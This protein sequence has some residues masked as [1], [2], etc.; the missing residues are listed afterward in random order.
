LFVIIL[1]IQA[2]QNG[3]NPMCDLRSWNRRVVTVEY[4]CYQEKI[5]AL[6]AVFVSACWVYKTLFENND[7]S[8]LI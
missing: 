3:A 5:K 4:P 6:I 2:A 7:I 1:K 8:K